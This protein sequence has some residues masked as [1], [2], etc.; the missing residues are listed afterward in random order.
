MVVTPLLSG[1]SKSQRLF[2]DTEM[3]GQERDPWQF[4]DGEAPLWN[5]YCKRVGWLTC[6]FE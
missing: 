5:W 2:Q 4:S 1:T 6:A 3:V